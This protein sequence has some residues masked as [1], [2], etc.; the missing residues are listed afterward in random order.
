[1]KIET[2]GGASYR[3]VKVHKLPWPPGVQFLQ[4][5]PVAHLAGSVYWEKRPRQSGCW[6]RR[7][8]S[9]SVGGTLI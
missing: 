3:F 4:D 6:S 9:V 2:K 8:C 1:M 5:A 7:V